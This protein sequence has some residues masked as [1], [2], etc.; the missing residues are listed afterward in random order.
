MQGEVRVLTAG[1]YKVSAAFFGKQKPMFQLLVNGSVALRAGSH[2]PGMGQHTAARAAVCTSDDEH[3]VLGC[4]VTEYLMIPSDACL[5][6]LY[7]SQPASGRGFLS[8][9]KAC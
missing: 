9:H 3:P 4:S 7:Q 2:M 5:T 8:L 6:V 1:V